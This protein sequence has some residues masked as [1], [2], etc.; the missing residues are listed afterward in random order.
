MSNQEMSRRDFLKLGTS[1]VG[2]GLIS[3]AM[4]IPLIARSLSENPY[5]DF[6]PL[7]SKQEL[8][9]LNNNRLKNKLPPMIQ[10]PVDYKA[11][12]DHI[13]YL[14]SM[15]KKRGDPPTISGFYFTFWVEPWGEILIADMDPPPFFLPIGTKK[16]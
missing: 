6:N 1:V 15:G 2:G 5:L 12:K 9:Q 16:P 14:K 11:E 3:I 8:D 7:I 13:G 10:F 4:G